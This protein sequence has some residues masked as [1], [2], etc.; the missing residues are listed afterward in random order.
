MDTFTFMIAVVMMMLAIQFEQNWLVLG[1]A[2]VLAL[3][4]KDIKATI[5]LAISGGVLYMF[6]GQMK[7]LWPFV[8]FGL[9]ILS[10][11]LG[12]G[13]KEQASPYG[14]MGMGMGMDEGL[15]PI[16]MGGY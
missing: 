7:E 12:I 5:L 10:I 14:D 9:V 3:T 13:K 2:V 6:A 4:T 1:I 11:I 15:P 8:I 16:G